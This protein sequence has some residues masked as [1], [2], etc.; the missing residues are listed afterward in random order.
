LISFHFFHCFS[1]WQLRSISRIQL[2][3]QI[4]PSEP[5]LALP[6]KKF[7]G[8]D[9]GSGGFSVAGV[10]LYI[11]AASQNS[12]CGV[13]PGGLDSMTHTAATGLVIWDGGIVLAK[14]LEHQHDKLHRLQSKGQSEVHIVVDL[15]DKHVIEVGSGPGVIWRWQNDGMA[16]A[17]RWH[18][19]P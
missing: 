1:L 5:M 8:F 16:M 11:G 15:N 6:F 18:V 13:C 4:N 10:P 7:G 3:R 9:F 19:R 2:V 17:C 14:F 12:S